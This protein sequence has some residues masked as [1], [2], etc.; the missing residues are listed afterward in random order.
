MKTLRK[1]LG[2]DDKFFDLLEASAIEAQGSVQLLTELLRDTTKCP[3]M[4]AFVQTRRKDK[5]ITEEITEELCKTFV[6]PLER[7]DIEALSFALYKI[8]KTAE[9]FSEKFILCREA[10][11]G[12][13]FSR[14]LALL[15]QASAIIVQMVRQLR[16]RK[17]L[18]ALKD[19]NSRMH[20]LE[21]EADKLM[22]E[23]IRELYSGKHDPLR[24]IINM[25]LYETLEKIIDRC[26]DAG[27]VIFQI[28]LKYS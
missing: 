27:N 9:K 21:G 20:Y 23:L 14:Q 8:P 5:R 4:D 19:Q 17:H 13:D 15:E 12:V 3:T 25:D 24:V 16:G 10:L 22:L 7:E 28:V 1:L 18:D 11:G 6:T 2:Y 26:R